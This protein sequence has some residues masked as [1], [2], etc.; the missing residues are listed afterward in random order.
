MQV[1]SLFLKVK[2]HM[3]GGKVQ[4]VEV[5]QV[6]REAVVGVTHWVVVIP[7]EYA[8]Q[9]KLSSTAVTLTPWQV[10]TQGIQ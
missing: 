7:W 3:L 2:K 10:G 1:P 4:G 8:G 5:S 6:C 9:D